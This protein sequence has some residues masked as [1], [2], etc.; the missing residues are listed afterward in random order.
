MSSAYKSLLSCYLI[1]L[2]CLAPSCLPELQGTLAMICVARFI[3]RSGLSQK[4]N[5]DK[6]LV[7]CKYCIYWAV[8]AVSSGSIAISQAE[9][10]RQS[11]C[12]RPFAFSCGESFFFSAL[13]IKAGNTCLQKS[14]VLKSERRDHTKM[15]VATRVLQNP[16]VFRHHCFPPKYHN[17]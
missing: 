3:L 14:G 6:K 17:L 15:S 1:I 9:L 13:S 8:F 10:K 7:V 11:S 12:M 2:Y 16:E 5:L 4:P